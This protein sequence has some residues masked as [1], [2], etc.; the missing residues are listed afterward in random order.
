LSRLRAID[1]SAL[2]VV[3]DGVYVGVV[4][5]VDV[6]RAAT[7]GASPSE[8]GLLACLREVPAL[9]PD[10]KLA[11]ALD[12]MDRHDVDALAVVDDAGGY[13]VLS[14]RAIR[15]FVRTKPAGAATGPHG[16]MVAAELRRE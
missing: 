5:L 16:P 7:A 15:R 14:R 10:A 2:P 4:E 13:A 9:N 12:R 3:R 1:S 6:H 8:G 11:D